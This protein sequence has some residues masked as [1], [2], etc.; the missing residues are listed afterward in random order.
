VAVLD[1]AFTS[2]VDRIYAVNNEEGF[3]ADTKNFEMQSPIITT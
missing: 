3:S 2:N 1:A